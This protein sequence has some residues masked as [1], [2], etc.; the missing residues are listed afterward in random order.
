MDTVT[1]HKLIMDND[2]N[3]VQLALPISDPIIHHEYSKLVPPH[4]HSCLE[5]LDPYGI[6]AKVLGFVALI[7]D[8]P[9]GI[10][11][12]TADTLIHT[13]TIHLLYVIEPYREK[14]IETSLLEHLTIELKRLGIT[15]ASFTYL[16]NDPYSNPL[17]K[18]FSEQHWS[19]P[20]PLMIE[21]LFKWSSFNPSWLQKSIELEKDFEIFPWKNIRGAEKKHLKHKYEQGR[22]PNYVFPFEKNYNKLEL[23][24]SLGLRYKDEVVGWM[25][26]NRQSPDTIRY[27]SLYLED[28]F[29]FTGYWLKLLIEA[30]RIHHDQMPNDIGELEINL[31]QIN[32][33]W[34]KFIE[35]RLFPFA[36]EIRRKSQFWKSLKPGVPPLDPGN[37]PDC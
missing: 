6:K 33:R 21:C 13:A 4:L 8:K 3:I 16:E 23:K 12:A 5:G 30:L 25:L 19:G 27:T 18:T 31:Y 11:L 36:I 35:K 17:K 28:E 1:K 9:V 37:D 14:K 26:V 29:A 2:I 7:H 15:L 22:I 32:E 34:L 24:N 10:I 20:R